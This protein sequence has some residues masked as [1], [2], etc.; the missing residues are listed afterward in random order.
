MLNVRDNPTLPAGGGGL[1]KHNKG[2]R[3]SGAASNRSI[4]VK[5]IVKQAV[6]VNLSAETMLLLLKLN[7]L[8]N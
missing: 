4:T 7:V 6:H 2:M 8:G 3:S 1:D 5:K